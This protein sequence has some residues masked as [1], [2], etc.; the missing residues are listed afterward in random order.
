L[1]K[2]NF[3]LFIFALLFVS[4][5]AQL[6]KE[7]WHWQFG[8]L[9]EVDF[10]SGTAVPVVGYS[11][12]DVLEGCASISDRS[13]GQLLF[14]TS[15][16]VVYDKN[17]NTMANYY[18][19]IGGQGTSTQAA[20]IIP[21]PNSDSL[22]YL[23][24]ADQGGYYMAANT[25]VH[26]S[27]IDM[28][29]N[30]GLGQVTIKNKLLTP[31]PA[32]EKLTAVR[33]CNGRD[34]WVITHSFNSNAF[35]AYLV[36]PLGIDTVPVISHTGLLH[37][38]LGGEY[39]E[40][41][42][43]LK[44][45]P[46][47]KKLASAITV[48]IPSLEIF[49]FDNTTGRVSNPTTITYTFTPDPYLG[50]G[51]YGISFSPDNSKLYALIPSNGYLFQYDLS[52]GVS[53]TIIASQT[54][55]EHNNEDGA[56]QLG[57]D[58]KIYIATYGAGLSVINNPNNTGLSCNYQHGVINLWGLSYCK[59]G[60]P[61]FIDANGVFNGS[62]AQSNLMN[63]VQ[64]NSFVADSLHAG[65]GFINYQW[66]TGDTTSS[67][68]INQPGV[69]WVTIKNPTGCVYTDTVHAYTINPLNY[70]ILK[71][72]TVCLYRASNHSTTYMVN[73]TVSGALSY[74]W[75][76]G[77]TDPVKSFTLS[78]A[79]WIDYIF[80]NGCR[81]RDSFNLVVWRYPYVDLGL[82]QY[83]CDTINTPILLNAGN[84]Y[85]PYTYLWSNGATTQAISVNSPGIY[86][87]T[88]KDSS[89]VCSTTDSV[90]IYLYSKG[91]HYVI[92]DTVFCKGQLKLQCSTIGGA[93]AQYWSD[94][95]TNYYDLI[96]QPGIYTATNYF[97]SSGCQIIDSFYVKKGSAIKP[98]MPNVMWC[99]DSAVTLNAG[100]SYYTSYMWS[101]GEITPS[102]QVT[103]SGNYWVRVSESNDCEATDTLINVQFFTPPKIN[104]L[105]DTTLCSNMAF[106]TIDASYP[107]TTS[108]L[109]SD[110][111]NLPNH[112]ISIPGIYWVTYLLTNTCITGDTFNVV[113]KKAIITDTFPNIVTPNNDNIND[114]ID[115]KNFQFSFMHIEIFNRWGQKIFESSDPESIW[116]PT[117]DDG[118]YFYTLNFKSECEINKY[119]TL[120]G[121]ITVIR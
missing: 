91:P 57:P 15:G 118:T 67:I 121:F 27:I 6:G 35:N 36:S 56:L 32:T 71:D 41:A 62:I 37:S 34:Y 105:K 20:L 97:A 14:Y 5:K 109:W 9:A 98:I 96:Q 69:Y 116:R 79:Y 8:K 87:V 94:G 80:N 55:I 113:A 30:G 111:F 49:D 42:G 64:C 3:V 28:S 86:W 74:Q 29:L 76:D 18:G 92:Q 100:A 7:A 73:A 52:S 77:T 108:Y 13:T 43:Y 39:R 68:L 83:I 47:G 95:T 103:T 104:I 110:G 58:G 54:L 1:T 17:N 50:S 107:G 112:D 90:Q 24:T 114:N 38:N 25:G 89:G 119:K 40:T 72:T 84:S 115:F 16:D 44:A 60:L 10:S 70:N 93:A 19:I 65:N 26:Y 61:N 45:S 85:P 53:S 82:N 51:P 117:S 120:K 88:L 59:D 99:K 4:V 22:Y 102:I 33:H 23:I 63:I 75:F 2:K 101:T 21:K 48:N 66:S 11:G 106:L 46:N 78:G 81:I 12:M 31:P